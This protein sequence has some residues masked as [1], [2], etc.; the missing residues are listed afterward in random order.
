MR[1][2]TVPLSPAGNFLLKVALIN[3]AADLLAS[4]ALVTHANT[5]IK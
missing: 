5:E 4:I 3:W 2:T 1:K